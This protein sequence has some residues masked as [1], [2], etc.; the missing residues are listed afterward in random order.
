MIAMVQSLRLEL[1]MIRVDYILNG[2][3]EFS[4][5]DSFWFTVDEASKEIKKR[6][7]EAKIIQAYELQ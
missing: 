5:F 2:K 6:M 1:L 4:L 3:E 7:P